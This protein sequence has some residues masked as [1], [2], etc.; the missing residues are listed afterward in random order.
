MEQFEKQVSGNF[1][2]HLFVT[3]NK[4]DINLHIKIHLY[5]LFEKGFD[6]DCDYF[7]MFYFY[8]IL[9]A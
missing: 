6:K 4:Y 3:I 5:W 8:L 7:E 2:F 9:G 1:P